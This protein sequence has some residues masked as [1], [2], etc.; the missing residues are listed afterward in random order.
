M[1]KVAKTS[2]G[3]EFN[4]SGSGDLNKQIN[5]MFAKN[6][7]DIELFM[8]ESLTDAM[9]API[10]D[11]LKERSAKNSTISQHLQELAREQK[12]P[13]SF[14]SIALSYLHMICNRVFIAKQRVHEMVVY[15]YLYRYYSK[16]LYTS[17]AKNT[18]SKQVE[19]L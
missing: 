11:I 13:T 6:E 7:R 18:D 2:F 9:Y 15:D 4:R 1:L 3:N 19:M 16:Q 8:D 14:G 17:K 10:W 5:E 12:L